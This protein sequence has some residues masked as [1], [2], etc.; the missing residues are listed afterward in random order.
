MGSWNLS[1]CKINAVFTFYS[2]KHVTLFTAIVG[3]YKF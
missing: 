1:L 3:A 2:Q